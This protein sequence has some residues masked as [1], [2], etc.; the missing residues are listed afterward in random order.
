M[1]ILY[2]AL[3]YDYGI[4]DRGY[5][6][7]HYNF[8]DSLHHMGQDLIYFDYATLLQKYGRKQMNKLLL[9][10][11]KSEKPDLM[12]TVLTHDEL[13]RGTVKH[14][15]ES[16]DTRTL[17]WFCDD[18]WRF[19]DFSR[20]WA[21][22]FNWVVT[23]SE[24]ALQKY[25]AIGYDNV[26]KSQWACN[27]FLYKK[28]DLSVTGSVTFIGQPHSDRRQ[29]IEAI[30]QTGIDVRAWGTGWE[31]G[32]I[33]QEEMIRVFNQ[34]KINLNLS[35][36]SAAASPGGTHKAADAALY[37]VYRAIGK[38]PGG[39]QLKTLGKKWLA[40]TKSART[41]D[42]PRTLP[43]VSDPGYKEQIKGR[44]FEVPGCGGFLL[45]GQAE[46]LGEYYDIDKEIVCFDDVPEL[47]EKIKYYL[48]NEEERQAIASAGYR[49]TIN[50][51]TYV[52]RFEQ[53]FKKA[54][55]EC[56]PGSGIPKEGARDG[57]VTEIT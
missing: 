50:E 25:A 19:D 7:E 12:F 14:I 45:T 54:G 35:N 22:C 15:S 6:F 46:N 30:R 13:D 17:N 20:R 40:R 39:P 9:E 34:S 51:H 52:H 37:P 48:A 10:T 23:T 43:V 55:L 26:I 8:Y 18:H 28:L 44:N 38:V 5:S 57:K 3:K 53:I 4:Q 32:R 1:K 27:N 47:L 56:Q 16:T 29:I 49:R 42:K 24:G 11:V 31:S 33:S 41:D 21:P 2:V 36:S